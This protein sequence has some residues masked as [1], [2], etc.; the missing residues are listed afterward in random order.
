[1]A[2]VYKFFAYDSS[3]LMTL[4]KLFSCYA[5]RTRFGSTNDPN[6]PSESVIKAFGEC[7]ERLSLEEAGPNAE[8]N[9]VLKTGLEGCD[10]T[11]FAQAVT[12]YF[13]FTVKKGLY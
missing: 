10:S 9:R 11:Y 3:Y 7:L 2:A 12:N 6:F 4:V 8:L 13:T 1:M 5:N